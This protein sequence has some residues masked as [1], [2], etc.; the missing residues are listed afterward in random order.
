MKPD[1]SGSLRF[2]TALVGLCINSDIN[3]KDLPARIHDNSR[4]AS[5][6]S[7]VQIRFLKQRDAEVNLVPLVPPPGVT[8]T[9]WRLSAPSAA[10]GSELLGCSLLEAR[11]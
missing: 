7:L 3:E 2:F 5:V 4:L 1:K 8:G 6:E 11:S 9:N 10:G